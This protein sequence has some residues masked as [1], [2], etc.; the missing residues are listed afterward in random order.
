MTCFRQGFMLE[1]SL[2]EVD[3]FHFKHVEV[4]CSKVVQ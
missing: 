3:G 4:A 1:G 2:E